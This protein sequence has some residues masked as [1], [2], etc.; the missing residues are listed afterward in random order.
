MGLSR[1]R[2]ALLLAF[3]AVIALAVALV[4]STGAGA[5]SNQL[6]G[7]ARGATSS[8]SW[9]STRVD[10]APSWLVRRR[11][12]RRHHEPAGLGADQPQ[13]AVRR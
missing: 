1:K 7:A 13:R 9:A 8:A 11:G 5:A 2:L 6:P 12:V 3:P 10:K 4:A